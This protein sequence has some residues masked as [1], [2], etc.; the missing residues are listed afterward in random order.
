MSLSSKLSVGI[1]ILTILALKRGDPLTSE[2]IAGSVCTN[3]VVI[4]RLLGHLRAAGFVESKT[5]VG[6]GWLLVADP[7]EINLL[8]VLRVVEPQ[9][10]MFALH[11]G[12]PNP[13]C[14]VACNIQKVLMDIY[15]E[16]W[17][18]MAKRLERSTIASV[19][20]TLLERLQT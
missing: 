20:A 4:R 14:F 13:E 16:A 18:G 10:Q 5:G 12:E 1:H 19:T 15:D 8:E 9:H 7:A 11:H 6:G 2:Y 3:P 17:E